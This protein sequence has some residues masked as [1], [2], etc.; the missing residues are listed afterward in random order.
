MEGNSRIIVRKIKGHLFSSIQKHALTHTM[1]HD[2]MQDHD[3]DE[4]QAKRRY[5]E[6]K[7]S[8]EKCGYNTNS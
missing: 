4:L 1:Q 8:E 2:N 7:N 3:Y 5:K 6:E